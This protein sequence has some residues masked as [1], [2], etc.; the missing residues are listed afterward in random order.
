MA[1]LVHGLLLHARVSAFPAKE[2]ASPHGAARYGR[3]GGPSA[4]FSSPSDAET[5][6][7]TAEEQAYYDGCELIVS[8]LVVR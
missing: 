7:E 5:Y 1:G 2:S 6:E 8:G 4:A 3:P